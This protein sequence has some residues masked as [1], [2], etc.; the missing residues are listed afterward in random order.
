MG[1][2]LECDVDRATCALDVGSGNVHLDRG[3]RGVGNHT[4]QKDRGALGS[5]TVH[6]DSGER[7]VGSYGVAEAE[8]VHRLLGRPR[9]TGL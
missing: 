2:H 6:L 7:D 3:V 1:A 5:S 9:A 4:Y 8:A